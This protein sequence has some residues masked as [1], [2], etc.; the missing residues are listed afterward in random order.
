MRLETERMI[1]RS[2]RE[3]DVDE[4]A[5]IVAQPEVMKFISDGRV[6]DYATAEAFVLRGIE[7]ERDRG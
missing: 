5:K 3:S 6:N 4:Y 2:W 1:I 7:V